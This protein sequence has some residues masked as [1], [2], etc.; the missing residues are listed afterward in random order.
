MDTLDLLYKTLDLLLG[1]VRNQGCIYVNVVCAGTILIQ[2]LEVDNRIPVCGRDELL[3]QVRD[4]S[5]ALV[6]L[7][8]G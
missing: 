3:L 1:Q 8:L 4:T 2:D 7:W 5:I 6:G